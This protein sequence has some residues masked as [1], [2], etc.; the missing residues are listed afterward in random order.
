MSNPAGS[1]DAEVTGFAVA[2]LDTGN[3]ETGSDNEPGNGTID[4]LL[5]SNLD[6]WVI[7]GSSITWNVVISVPAG[8][9]GCELVTWH[10]GQ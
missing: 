1:A 3:A 8:S 5:I 4:G 9:V 2:F 6:D 7:P 10:D